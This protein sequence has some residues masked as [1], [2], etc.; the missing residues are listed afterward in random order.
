MSTIKEDLILEIEKR[1]EDS[2]L[3][4]SNANLLK[5]LI[6]NAS[7]DDEA[8]AIATLGTTYKR[9]GL[10]FDK[11]LEKITNTITY[12][13]KNEELSFHNDDKKPTHKLIIG[14]NYKAL[15]NLLIGYKGKV[16]VIYIDPP[17]GKDSMGE[18][19]QTNYDNSITRDNL[20]SMLYPR[21]W[22]AKQLLSPQGVIFC[23]IDD[24]NQSYLKCLFDE[25][26][27]ERNFVANFIW[28]KRKTQA[29]LTKHVASRHEYILMYSK[30]R[31]VLE[32]KKLPLRD[33]YVQ[34][35]YK[36]PD[37]D[38]RGLWMTKPIA[39]PDNAPNKEFELD[40][41]NGR[42]VTAK[43]RVSQE[44]YDKWLKDNLIVIPN[45]GKGMPRAKVFLKDI[46]GQIPNTLLMDIATTEEGSKEIE[47]CLGSNGVFA[48]PKPTKLLNFLFSIIPTENSIILDFFAGSGTTGHSV[49]DLNAQ[50]GGERTF[51]LCQLNEKTDT[52]PNG[53]A[54]DVTAKRLKRIMTGECYDG[55]TNF[56]WIK[57]HEAY[58]G[59]LDVYDINEVANFE[60]SEGKT[61]L[62]VI[63]ETLY[64][65]EKF[66]TL[67]EKTN[68]VC[69]NFAITQKEEETK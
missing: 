60:N 68:W 12:F 15:L 22:L 69:N 56:D 37:N 61:P 26:F 46:E 8:I 20:L 63:D 4:T 66:K 31:D 39:S 6:R 64:G 44:S 30:N 18:F 49:L 7:S 52:T 35:L 51:I 25:V 40:L 43:W 1:V 65:V 32:T 50:D 29:N 48:Y 57:K 5:K 67:E 9:T 27:G 62:N 21:L 2:I 34:S 11:R 3:E 42:K 53:I 38:P 47:K 55:N 41:R 28:Q 23:S 14:D 45:D 58:G 54:H 10:H 13:S 24:R 19:A 17:Y 33:S 36:N 59:N 16:D